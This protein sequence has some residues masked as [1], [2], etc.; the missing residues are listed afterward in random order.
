MISTPYP[1]KSSAESLE[2]WLQLLDATG[3]HAL[4]WLTHD[5]F[6]TGLKQG[7]FRLAIPARDALGLAQGL[8]KLGVMLVGVLTILLPA[9]LLAR[10]SLGQSLTVVFEAWGAPIA[11]LLS[12]QRIRRPAATRRDWLTFGAG[13]TVAFCAA[14]AWG[15]PGVPRVVAIGIAWAISLPWMMDRLIHAAAT[16]TLQCRAD[17]FNRAIALGKIR[18][19]RGR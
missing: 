8:P 9:A 10:W 14:I 19:E 1:V 11:T 3:Q 12:F 4:A 15:V 18:I 2:A 5:V 16:K 7:R 17:H 13:I 6:R